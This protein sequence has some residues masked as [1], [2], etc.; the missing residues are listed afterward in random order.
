MMANVN[1][2][3]H[4]LAQTNEGITY[5][6]AESKFAEIKVPDHVTYKNEMLLQESAASLGESLSLCIH[7]GSGCDVWFMHEYGEGQP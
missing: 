6:V 5:D 7:A 3:L 2:K 1:R 4:W